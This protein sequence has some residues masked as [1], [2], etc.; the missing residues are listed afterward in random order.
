MTNILVVGGGAREH[1]LA[2]AL[3]QS[4]QRPWVYVA[5]GNPGVDGTWLGALEAGPD[6]TGA[7][8]ASRVDIAAGDVDALLAYACAQQIDLTVVGPEAPLMLGLADRF[9]ASGLRVVGPDRASARL[10]G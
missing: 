6:G 10:E 3:G 4:P 2:W 7:P 9:R 1:A 8:R 5:P